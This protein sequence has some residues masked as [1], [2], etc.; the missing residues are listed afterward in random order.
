MHGRRLSWKIY[1]ELAQV[2]FCFDTILF[3]WD[4]YWGD[5][6]I[7]LHRLQVFNSTTRHPYT[8]LCSP[9]VKP[10]SLTPYLPSPSSNPP[11]SSG[12]HHSVVC[13]HESL[14]FLCL[15]PQR[16]DAQ[17][18]RRKDEVRARAPEAQELR[19]GAEA[20]GTGRLPAGSGRGEA[21]QARSSKATTCGF[22]ET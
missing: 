2:L 1:A 20:R 6:F 13:V 14:F 15:I 16:I 18:G 7:K 10:P 9:Q 4:T 11:P 17:R 19:R 22:D 8:A 5:W 12:S 3:I 21:P